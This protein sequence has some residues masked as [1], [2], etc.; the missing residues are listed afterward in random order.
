MVD[1]P[2]SQRDD[3]KL[4]DIITQVNPDYKQPSLLRVRQWLFAFCSCFQPHDRDLERLCQDEGFLL[5]P[6]HEPGRKTLVLDLD[7]TLVHSVF[8][9]AGKHD[10]V[11]QIDFNGRALTIYVNIRPY[12]QE[13]LTR[14]AELYE[15][16]VYTASLAKYANPLMDKIDPTGK[17]T[18]RLFRE[19]CVYTGNG[20]VK[21]LRRLGRDLKGTIIV[22]VTFK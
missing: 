6:V 12:V 1:M 4:A 17:V 16:V 3:V 18:G 15:V 7:E 9:S 8:E 13:F 10:I 14:V 2:R 20:Y 21:D 11:M 5:P 19:S 22:D